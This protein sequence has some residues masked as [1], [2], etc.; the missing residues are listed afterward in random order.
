VAAGPPAP[1]RGD[2]LLGLGLSIANRMEA[3]FA[4]GIHHLFRDGFQH[5]RDDRPGDRDE[6]AN[7]VRD[8]IALAALPYFQ[9]GSV[10]PLHDSRKPQNQPM[11]VPAQNS[12]S[13][14]VS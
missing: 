4:D 9:G 10:S 6:S 14:P 3:G 8:R 12:G 13:K 11:M 5:A 7:L 1:A 2:E